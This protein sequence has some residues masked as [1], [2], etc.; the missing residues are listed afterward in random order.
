M[1][2]LAIN[3]YLILS[4]SFGVAIKCNTNYYTPSCNVRCV[5]QN[6]CTGG[7]YTCHPVTGAKI[8]NF[9]FVDPSTDCV[10]RNTS[11]PLCPLSDG[12][13]ILFA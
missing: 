2:A 1:Y 11:V 10:M 6:S 8:C 3:V 7:H 4:I 13:L 5:E 12:K 9:G